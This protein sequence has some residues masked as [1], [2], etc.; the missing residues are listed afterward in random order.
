MIM[1]NPPFALYWSS[2]SF[3]PP[4]RGSQAQVCNVHW[5][6]RSHGDSRS[7]QWVAAGQDGVSRISDDSIIITSIETATVIAALPRGFKAEKDFLDANF[8]SLQTLQNIEA[9]REDLASV[10]VDLGFAPR[11]FIQVGKEK[12]PK[13]GSENRVINTMH[14]YMIA[15]SPVSAAS[16]FPL[17]FST[18]ST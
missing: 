5:K 11:E 9:G 10:L 12:R 15:C 16:F 3:S 1:V 17:L 7:I 4:G 2:S 8:L 18:L 13:R 6:E 14:I